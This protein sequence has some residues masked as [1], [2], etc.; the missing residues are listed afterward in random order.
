MAAPGNNLQLTTGSHVRDPWPFRTVSIGDCEDESF[1]GVRR[2]GTRLFGMMVAYKHS[3]TNDTTGVISRGPS[4]LPG[5]GP[6]NRRRLDA[7]RQKPFDR[8]ATFADG[9]GGGKCFVVFTS[10]RAESAAFY[11]H[12]LARSEGVGDVFVFE[13]PNLVVK[14]LG[15]QRSVAVLSSPLPMLPVTNPVRE[16]MPVVPIK[17]PLAGETRYFSYH[18]LEIQV[19]N[20]RLDDGGCAGRMCDRGRSLSGSEGCGCFYARGAHTLVLVMDVTFPVSHEYKMSEE[21]IITGF[22]SLR[23]TKFFIPNDS[24]LARL[25]DDNIR[26]SQQ[27]G[28]AL[29]PRVQEL[30]RYVNANNGWSLQGWL[31]TGKTNDASDQLGR[32]AEGENLASEHQ[33]PHLSHLYPTELDLDLPG[34]TSRTISITANNEVETVHAN[35]GDD[36]SSSD[37]DGDEVGGH[38]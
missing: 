23:T 25:R 28:M 4:H 27:F 13:E 5:S 9:S 16:V 15:D 31:R 11:K 14:W 24:H 17:A 7:M 20:V 22:R 38:E 37:E 33:R 19:A 34:Y 35:G 1:Q 8:I 2:E 18:G 32:P 29:R 6:N 12:C 10:S 30:V 36:E 26:E 3:S 21:E